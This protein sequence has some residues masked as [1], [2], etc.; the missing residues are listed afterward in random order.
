MNDTDKRPQDQPKPPAEPRREPIRKTPDQ[1]DTRRRYEEGVPSR[2][3][4]PKEK[5]PKQE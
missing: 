3:Q 4:A 2:Q 5:P 1:G